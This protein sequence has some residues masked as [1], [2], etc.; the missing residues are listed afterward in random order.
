MATDWTP[1]SWRARPAAQMPEYPDARSARPGRGA[2]VAVSAAG[3]RR[4]GAQSAEA[5]RRRLRRQSFSAAGRGLRGIVRRVPPRQHPRHVARPVA[6]GRGPDLRR[7]D[8]GGQGRP[9]GRSVRQA[10]LGADRA[11]GRDRA[12]ELSRRHRQRTRVRGGGARAGSGAP[13]PG[14]RPGGGDAQSAARVHRRRLRLADAGAQLDAGLRRALAAGRTLPRHGEP[15]H[16]GAGVHG[17]LRRDRRQHPRDQAHLAVHLARGAAARFRAGD[18]PG[19][20]D[21]RHVVRHERASALGGRAHAPAGQRARRVLPGSGQSARAQGRAEDHAGRA[22]HPVRPAQSG[23]R[24]R[25][26][27]R[28]RAH[29]PRPGRAP[30]AAA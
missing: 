25:P 19:R 5:A 21:L 12:A 29:G 17:S 22:A 16:R 3:V 23:Q 27:D 10:P 4:R 1:A 2:A 7:G 15:D 9:H 14:L 11:P 20:F 6:D 30:A 13:G 28:D 24:A 18:D 26:A 8:A